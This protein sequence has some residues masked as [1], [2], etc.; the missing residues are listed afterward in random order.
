[1]PAT[2]ALDQQ[3]IRGK[4]AFGSSEFDNLPNSR[5]FG[6]VA[7]TSKTAGNRGIAGTESPTNHGFKTALSIFV[8]PETGVSATLRRQC[9]PKCVQT[10]VY[11][12]FLLAGKVVT[13]EVQRA[14]VPDERSARFRFCI[15]RPRAAK[16]SAAHGTKALFEMRKWRCNCPVTD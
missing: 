2:I 13:S 7:K 3:L 16:R 12:S 15:A 4:P 10:C 11:T 5:G 1:M 14:R 6:R 9:G 8:L